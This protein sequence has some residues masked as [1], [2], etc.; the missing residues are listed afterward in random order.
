MVEMS[1]LAFAAKPRAKIGRE[2]SC[3]ASWHLRILICVKFVSPPVLSTSP[4]FRRETANLRVVHILEVSSYASND[5][6]RPA[7]TT[8]NELN[9]GEV[10]I[11]LQKVFVDVGCQLRC[12]RDFEFLA[13]RLD[14]LKA[15][16]RRTAALRSQAG[17]G[18]NR[19]FRGLTDARRTQRQTDAPRPR[20]C[21]SLTE[22]STK[23]VKR[24]GLFRMDLEQL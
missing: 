19:G 4:P 11:L 23:G 8:H 10:L 3:R 2:L 14:S 20:V 5:R 9:L 13:R 16:E 22:C 6:R 12:D 17:N 1:F 15:V 21:A 7:A 18:F 24:C